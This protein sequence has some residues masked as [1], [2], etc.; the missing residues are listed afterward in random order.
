MKNKKSLS[1]EKKFRLTAFVVTAVLCAAIIVLGIIYVSTLRKRTN[2][3]SSDN[4]AAGQTVSAET[5]AVSVS[6]TAKKTDESVRQPEKETASAPDAA[7]T[8][9]NKA[10]D[11]QADDIKIKVFTDNE[12]CHFK[13]SYSGNEYDECLIK[14]EI[15][16]GRSD[17]VDGVTTAVS[18]KSALV[19]NGA[20][21][22]IVGARITVYGS[23]RTELFSKTIGVESRTYTAAAESDDD[24]DISSLFA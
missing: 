5:T 14:I 17:Y 9:E 11:F 19:A 24:V 1:P 7:E 13:W 2:A 8:Q 18:T 15:T 16:D 21:E 12:G 4:I 6:E 3:E 23:D 22:D 10:S 20:A